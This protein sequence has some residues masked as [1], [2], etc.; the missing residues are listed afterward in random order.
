[1]SSQDKKI[2]QLSELLTPGVDD[3]LAIVDLNDNTTKKITVDNLLSGVSQITLQTNTVDNGD[4]TLLNLVAGTN[5]T[6]TDNGSGNVTI[7]ASGGGTPGGSDT[8]IQFNDNGNFGGSANFTYDESSFTKVILNSGSGEAGIYGYTGAFPLDVLNIAGGTRT[9]SGDGGIVSIA[10]GNTD[11]VGNGGEVALQAGGGGVTSGNGG[12][13][14]ILAGGAT[15]LG[16]GGRID[17]TAG[18]GEGTSKN[19]GPIT[20]SG[21]SAFGT[22]GNGGNINLRLHTGGSGGHAGRLN[23]S[24]LP[25]SA[26]GLASGDIW[27]NSNVLTIVP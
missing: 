20:I 14:E 27:L 5:V 7:D 24:G 12:P 8:Q 16:H 21:G 6:L 18:D 10:G 26:S 17:L 1:M 25:T 2:T 9:G 11:T 22:S 19:G 15:T 23:I 13:I 4:Q 3:V